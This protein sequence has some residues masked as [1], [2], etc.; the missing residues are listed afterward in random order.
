MKLSVTDATEVGSGHSP[1]VRGT[2]PTI[3]FWFIVVAAAVLWLTASAKLLSSLGAQPFLRLTDPVF[4]LRNRDV[5]LLVAL[6]EYGVSGYC[7]FAKSRL[8]KLIG[9]NYLGASMLVYRIIRSHG[10]LTLHDCPCLGTIARS[11]PIDQSVLDLLLKLLLCFL[12]SGSSWF[13]AV[14][15]ITMLKG[16][17]LAP[18]RSVR[19]E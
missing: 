6:I 1:S 14:R 9:I 17:L 15:V 12:L 13:L 8:L 18:N 19:A 2:T 16:R 4:H 10:G 7:L 11:L 3:E 5:L